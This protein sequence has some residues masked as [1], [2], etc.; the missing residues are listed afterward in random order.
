MNNRIDP[1]S[2]SP[3]QVK[4]EKSQPDYGRYEARPLCEEALTGE[5]LSDEALMEAQPLSD[6]TAA[7]DAGDSA[8]DRR[9]LLRNM[10]LA[11]VMTSAGALSAGVTEVFAQESEAASVPAR[12][13]RKQPGARIAP[14]GTAAEP[15]PAL[16]IIALN[17]M[18]FGPRPG[19]LADFLALGSTP[20]ERLTA[21]V[22]QQL[23][24]ASI[25]DSACDA[26]LAQQNYVTMD[27]SLTDVWVGYAIKKGD[28]NK[29]N[30]QRLPVKEVEKA[31]FLRAIHSKRQLNEVLADFWHNHFNVNGWNRWEAATFRHYDRDVIRAHMLGNFRE[32]LEAVAKSPAMI[33]YLDN[34][35]N[36]G[37]SPNENFARE[38]IEL[39]TMGAENYL[40]IIPDIPE[41]YDLIYDENGQPKGYV[42]DWVYG[43]TAS[44]GGWKTDT[45][46]GQ[47]YFNVADHFSY[48]KVFL[49]VTIPPDQEEGD[50]QL[51][52]DLLVN[53]PGTARH[54]ARKLCR[55]F[56]SDNP[57]E[58]IVQ[59]AADVFA[60]NIE[61][62]DQLAKVMRTI[63][64]SEEFKT[65]WGEK[66][67]R[68]F[69]YSVSLMRSVGY[70]FET[71]SDFFYRYNVGGQPL[72]AWASPDGFPDTR[73]RW[74]GT[75]S[76]L[77]RL[78]ICNYLID[79]KYSK[80]SPQGDIRYFRPEEQ[81]PAS[82][83]TP[84]ALVDYWSNRI[85]GRALPAVAYDEIVEFMADGRSETQELPQ[86][87]I[88]ERLRYMI[89]LIFMSSTFMLR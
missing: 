63:L 22:D 18:A 41:N 27:M 9:S 10:G 12:S 62:P 78:R 28:E 33:Y 82:I 48:Q 3:P 81:T 64:L 34:Q 49:G 14:M 16:E 88:D 53:H 55:R 70:D 84:I 42:D 20:D 29:D 77:Q 80:D 72:F 40:G 8:L 24:P 71:R 39:H 66:I 59:A 86:E 57:P 7:V 31:A 61:A 87:K 15:L 79:W 69:E 52:L 85:L 13:L 4:K 35:S 25:D 37:G 21:Y 17:R 5:A 23:N 65:T 45:E 11:A 76:M 30:D 68:P 43:A 46:T 38:L 75:M 89:A 54:I 47:F 67:K 74:T 19:D 56:I 50:G 6:G 26:I 58:T 60:A 73:G 44:F 32:M 2:C 1:V 83:K 36:T 51:V